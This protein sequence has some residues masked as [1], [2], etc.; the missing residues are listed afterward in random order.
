M[1][2]MEPAIL[3]PEK[4]AV[5]PAARWWRGL[6]TAAAGLVV[7]VLVAAVAPGHGYTLNIIMQAATYSIGV[8]GLVVVLGYCGQISLAQAGFLGIGAYVQAILTVHA[9]VPFLIATV[10]AV[11]VCGIFGLLLGFASL[12]LGGHYLAM[13][14]ISFQVILT[15][16]MTNWIGLT[17]GPDGVSGIPRPA[18]LEDGRAYLGLCLVLLVGAVLFTWRLKLSRLGRAMQAVRDNE[19]AAGTCG[20]DVFQI[21]VVAFGISAML[22]GLGGALFAG[23][24]SYV[25]PDQFTFDESIVML[26]MALLGGVQSPFGA[27]LG[28]FTLVI[29]PEWLR[30]LR[31][32][33][34]AIYGA[35]VILIMIFL[36]EGLWGWAAKRLYR[37]APVVEGSL[38]P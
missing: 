26:T 22:G 15:L 28:T 30:F 3:A 38:P 32:A 33:Y 25:S 1:S 21:K 34:L 24:F 18:G 5:I 4:L 2:T 19:I 12:R 11:I 7:A 10:A 17:G 13:V 29:L 31:E 9:G 16:V 35:A 27:L 37:R 20:I 6:P 23:A 8:A 14:T 36:P